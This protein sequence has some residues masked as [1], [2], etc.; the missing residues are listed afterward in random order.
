LYVLL[1]ASG[2]STV[3]KDETQS[4]NAQKC[5]DFLVKEMAEKTIRSLDA[6]S[7]IKLLDFSY[8][9]K[10]TGEE[11]ELLAATPHVRELNCHYT[12]KLNDSFATSLKY[13]PSIRVL[14][15]FG[16]SITEKSI[17]AIAELKDLEYLRLGFAFDQNKPP[18]TWTMEFP[19]TDNT[20]A[21]LQA[22]KNL[23]HL[24]IGDQCT[25]TDQGLRHL[26][27]Y[28]KLEYLGIVSSNITS[29]GIDFLKTLTWIKEIDIY[30]AAKDRVS[31]GLRA[32]KV[33]N[34]NGRRIHY[35]LYK[36]TTKN[37]AEKCLKFIVKETRGIKIK[38]S[39]KLL[40]VKLLDFSYN[41]KIS[42]AEFELLAETPN[43]RELRCQDAQN[44]NDSFAT[45][46]K[47]LPSIRVLDIDRTSVT[48]KSID[49]IAELKD[50]EF[51][52][53]G[54]AFDWQKPPETWT[55]KFPFTDDTLVKLQACKNLKYLHIGHQCTIT[56]QGLQN[57]KNYKNLEYLDIVSSDITPDGFEFLKTLTWIK[58][59][60]IILAPK[61]R[62]TNSSF[63]IN[64]YKKEGRIIIYQQCEKT[65]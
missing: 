38:S 9:N 48:E 10:I 59:I 1:F 49:A 40:E 13:M 55:M 26:K 50:L 3:A 32:T 16:T 20:L 39:D 64:E 57:L 8:N 46:L 19:F 44:L 60:S 36:N 62:G 43:V 11:F 25:I 35:Q 23:K 45:S 52:R 22:C 2:F 56:D 63:T 29:D 24:Y 37:D 54:F 41:N 33:E 65:K 12:R 6:L 47:Y 18:E 34:I 27:N 58:Q 21:K 14:V 31:D 15:L 5:L 42:G 51:L 61:D 28:K 4:G 30:T 7:M 53:L 17:D